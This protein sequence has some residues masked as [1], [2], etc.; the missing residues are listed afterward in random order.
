MMKCPICKTDSMKEITLE[1]TLPAQI[2]IQCGGIWIASNPYHAWRAQRADSP[3]QPGPRPFNP[4][5][6]TDQLKLCP[7]CGRM[8]ARYKI[9]PDVDYHLDR[10]NHCNGIWFD[11]H[12]WDAIAD[13]NLQD[14]LHEFFTHPWQERLHDQEDVTRM[15]QIYITKFGEVDYAL[16][17]NIRGWL[18]DHP[19]SQMLLAYLMSEDP[20]EI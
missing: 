18:R 12:E 13:R 1:E 2:C 11:K 20:Y 6:D 15:E 5:W 19:Q 17:Q 16:I 9:F 7:S 8:M 10:C 14:N 3:Q 4:Q